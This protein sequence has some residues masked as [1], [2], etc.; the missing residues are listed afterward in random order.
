MCE[1]YVLCCVLLKSL[2]EHHRGG[3]LLN[4]TLY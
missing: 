1:E 2:I 3:P 4:S